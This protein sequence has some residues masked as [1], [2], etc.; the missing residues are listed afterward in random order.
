MIRGFVDKE[1]MPV[2]QEI[3]EDTDHVIVRRILQGLSD[4]E[5]QKSPFPPECGLPS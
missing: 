3:D 1:I 4:L 2:R 5:L